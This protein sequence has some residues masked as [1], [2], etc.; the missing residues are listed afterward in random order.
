MAAVSIHPESVLAR[1][2]R[3]EGHAPLTVKL[4]LALLILNE[5]RGLAVVG[6]ILYAYFR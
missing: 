1:F 6:S 3:D 4:G 5:I 2:W